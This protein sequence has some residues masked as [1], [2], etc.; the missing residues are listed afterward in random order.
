MANINHHSNL[1]TKIMFSETC[2]ALCF[3]DRK[4]E[5]F[6]KRVCL[7]LCRLRDEG[8]EAKEVSSAI[9]YSPT[10][11]LIKNLFV[12]LCFF[13]SHSDLVYYSV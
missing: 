10:S 4:L 6:G 5:D 2:F 9:C 7:V 12:F 1:V 11:F 13:L 8:D 3:L